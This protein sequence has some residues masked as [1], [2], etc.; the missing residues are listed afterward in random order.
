[1]QKSLERV[2]ATS[3]TAVNRT[4]RAAAPA[5]ARVPRRVL[6]LPAE[7]PF[8]KS[9]DARVQ[10]GARAGDK[11]GDE[12]AQGCGAPA[13]PSKSLQELLST[14]AGTKRATRWV[15]GCCHQRPQKPALVAGWPGAWV[16]EGESQPPK[17]PA[18]TGAGNDTYVRFQN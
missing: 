14:G 12:R 4:W 15:G 1:M 6:P 5:A 11:Q 7:I 2:T 16:T 10:T 17:P 8:G 18:V 13:S 3:S 9:K